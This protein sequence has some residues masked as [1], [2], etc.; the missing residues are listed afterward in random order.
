M[1]CPVRMPCF[2]H[3]YFSN[4]LKRWY[5]N[6]SN[7]KIVVHGI[8]LCASENRGGATDFADRCSSRELEK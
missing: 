3:D 8:N 7:I 5:I 6:I 2:S 1:E 4:I